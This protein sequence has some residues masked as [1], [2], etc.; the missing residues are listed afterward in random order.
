MESDDETLA[1]EYFV[2]CDEYTL[3]N[4]E[5]MMVHQVAVKG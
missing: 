3:L 2:N 4:D 5:V 1:S